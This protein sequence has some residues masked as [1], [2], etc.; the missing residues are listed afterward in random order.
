MKP[1][2]RRSDSVPGVSRS[3]AAPSYLID[4]V[5]A[6]AASA[7]PSFRSRSAYSSSCTANRVTWPNSSRRASG[8]MRDRRRKLLGL[9]R[10]FATTTGTPRA[11]A[12]RRKFGHSSLS[13]STTREGFT[14]SKAA[15]TAHEKSNGHAIAGRSA[16]RLRASANPVSVVDETTTSQPGCR[17]RKAGTSVP[18]RFT[19][20]TLTAWNHATGLPV[21]L[22]TVT[23]PNSLAARSRR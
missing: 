13:A 2:V 15:A 5:T 12:A 3:P 20:P 22:G 17:A 11:F 21:G 4:P 14:A 7:T 8:A 10:A 23:C 19:S 1:S 9:R 16:N 18:S 6:I